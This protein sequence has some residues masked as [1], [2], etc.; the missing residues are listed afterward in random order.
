MRTV[1]KKHILGGAALLL[2][3]W[4]AYAVHPRIVWMVLLPLFAVTIVLFGL[5]VLGWLV[6]LM[7]RRTGRGWIMLARRSLIVGLAML[8]IWGTNW[9]LFDLA[10]H[11]AMAYAARLEP[12]LEQ[13]RMEHGRYPQNLASVPALPAMPRLYDRSRAY[14]AG[15]DGDFYLISYPVTNPVFLGERRFD[16][17]RR[18]WYVHF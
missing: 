4:G 9:W 17:N 18:E 10:D 8:A 7:F 1:G 14:Y 5:G 11:D 15:P 12:L 2:A 6:S 16:S 13:Y 3:L